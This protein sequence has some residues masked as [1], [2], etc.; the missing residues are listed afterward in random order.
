M[1]SVLAAAAL[2]Y[3]A[4][5]PEEINL[6]HRINDILSKADPSIG[7][8][9]DITSVDQIHAL[10]KSI[11]YRPDT[12]DRTQTPTETLT[13]KHGDCEDLSLLAYSLL[14]YLNLNPG[15]AIAY[16][17]DDPEAH[18][19]AYYYSP[20]L[21]EY[22]IFSNHDLFTAPTLKEAAQMLGYNNVVHSRPKGQQIREMYI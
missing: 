14:D 1:L 7:E 16:N 5:R 2:L 22:H 18:A 3:I 11:R 6:E 4:F 8:K 20:T 9:L 12:I 19:F 10:L 15:I 13:L 17:E 21:N